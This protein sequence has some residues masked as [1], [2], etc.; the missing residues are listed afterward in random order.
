M[1]ME[2]DV[3]LADGRVLRAYDSGADPA[4]RLVLAWHHGSPQTGAPL[5]P[6]LS[7]ASVRVG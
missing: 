6:V 1:V 7:A 2:R 4:T 3:R 5:E